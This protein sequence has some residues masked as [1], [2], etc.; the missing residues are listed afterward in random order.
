MYLAK[1]TRVKHK[2]P[3]CKGQNISSY[4][5]VEGNYDGGKYDRWQEEECDDCKTRW[6]VI[7][8]PV[9]IENIRAV[10]A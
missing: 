10:T 1:S 4:E 8:R 6:D 9:K 5:A 7:L 3:T 2:C